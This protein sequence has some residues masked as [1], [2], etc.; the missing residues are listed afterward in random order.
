M[1]WNVSTST[2]TEL[3]KR[4]RSNVPVGHG[5]PQRPTQLGTH[6]RP[7]PTVVSGTTEETS[8]FHGSTVEWSTRTVLRRVP[9]AGVPPLPTTLEHT[10]HTSKGMCLILQ[11]L[12]F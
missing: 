1:A 10:T 2:T 4:R 8:V 12:A 5:A 7:T 9:A 3:G 11:F 6:T